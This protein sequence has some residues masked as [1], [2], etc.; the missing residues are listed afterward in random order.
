M[1][2]EEQGAA[3]E[4]AGGL[5]GW[6]MTFADLM[7]LLMCFFV[8][9]LSFS[10]MDVA[11]FKQLAGSMQEAFGVQAEVEVK[12]MPRG[13]SIAPFRCPCSCSLASRTSSTSRSLTS[14][15]MCSSSSGLT[16]LIWLRAALTKSRRDIG[17][18]LSFMSGL[19]SAISENGNK[20]GINHN[21]L[22]AS[23]LGAKRHPPS[24]AA[25]SG[26]GGKTRRL[27]AV[28]LLVPGSKG[29]N[30]TADPSIMSAVL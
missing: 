25:G 18:W 4:E 22:R 8:L 2:D 20:M 29:R 24:S 19:V 28:S 16:S 15:I 21:N 6:V 7:T 9:M 23:G 13:T 1:A 17:C 27:T 10:E 26:T 5:P 3:E 30:R 11:K 12:T 14:S